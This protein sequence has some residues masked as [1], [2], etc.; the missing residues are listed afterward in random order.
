MPANI[1]NAIATASRTEFV[2]AF[3]GALLVAAAVVLLTGCGKSE[4]SK[5]HDAADRYIGQ[6][7][8]VRTVYAPA[9]AKANSALTVEL[10]TGETLYPDTVLFAAGR[11]ANTEELGLDA[12]R[13]VQERPAQHGRHAGMLRVV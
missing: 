9:I 7:N 11:V 6:V 8:G 12:A 2:D 13:M 4:R 10:S 3:G 5:R 1:G